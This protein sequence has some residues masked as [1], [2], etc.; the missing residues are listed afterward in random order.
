M[1][2]KIQKY[3]I[4]QNK[5]GKKYLHSLHSFLKREALAEHIGFC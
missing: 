5:L 2:K 3:K 4:K 1:K